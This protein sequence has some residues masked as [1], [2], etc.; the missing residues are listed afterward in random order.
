MK[1]VSRDW[2]FAFHLHFQPLKKHKQSFTQAASLF[3]FS[4]PY[5][6]R[7]SFRLCLFLVLIASV[8]VSCRST[9]SVT[10]NLKKMPANQLAAEIENRMYV[11]QWFSARAKVKYAD[12]KESQNFTA[13]I[14]FRH[15]SLS[16]TS[17]TGP[18]GVEAIRVLV[19]PDSIKILDKLKKQYLPRSINFIA[20]YLPFDFSIA[21]LEQVILGQLLIKPEG[22]MRSETDGNEHL[23]TTENKLVRT[24]VWVKPEH[25]NISR[26]KMEDRKSGNQ[27]NIVF[28]DYVEIDGK[29]F[30]HKRQILFMGKQNV[31]M[32]IEFSR[33]KF[34]EPTRFPFSISSKY[35][36]VN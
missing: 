32:D 1:V 12:E 30:S 19:Q 5:N 6:L 13:N 15:D 26:L 34:D 9:K 23:L 10:S 14:R 16:W 29:S 20:T 17:C 25:F 28:E 7:Y 35:G 36:K 21:S 8:A 4:F 18:L 33:V 24:W 27:L 22:K 3:G 11:A 2:K 31:R